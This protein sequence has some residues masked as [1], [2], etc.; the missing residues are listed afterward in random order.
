MKISLTV[1]K[2]I[3]MQKVLDLVEVTL[4]LAIGFTMMSLLPS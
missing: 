2:P 3:T 4:L 1:Q